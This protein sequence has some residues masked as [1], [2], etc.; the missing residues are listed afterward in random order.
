MGTIENVRMLL[1]IREKLAEFQKCGLKN[2][3]RFMMD[4]PRIWHGSV[5][6]IT[7]ESAIFRYQ[8]KRDKWGFYKTGIRNKPGKS[9][10]Y[11]NFM[12]SRGRLNTLIDLIPS[13]PF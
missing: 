5:Q 3:G 12:K 2:V 8:I 9:R 11:C 10:V 1:V 7:D 4:H 6:R 13:E